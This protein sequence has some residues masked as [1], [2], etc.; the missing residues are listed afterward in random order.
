M[1]DVVKF[2]EPGDKFY[3]IIQGVCSVMLPNSA[4]NNWDF[5]IKDFNNLQSWKNDVFD[6]KVEEFKK[7]HYDSYSY[8]EKKTQEQ[9]HIKLNCQTDSGVKHVHG[10]NP[11]TDMDLSKGE[12]DDL[13]T[14][15][16]YQK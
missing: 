15:E 1:Q 4:I 9:M 7:I 13:N 16:R 6:P 3:V 14:L 11:K 8:M 10:F 5:Q 12:L 2:G